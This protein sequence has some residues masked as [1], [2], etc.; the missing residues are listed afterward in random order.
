MAELEYAMERTVVIRAPRALVFRYF[1]DNQRWSAWWGAGSTIAAQ[2]GGK[3]YIRY[4]NGVEAS[5]EVVSVSEPASIRFTL[6]YASGKPMPPGGSMVTIELEEVAQGTRLHL[7]HEFSDSSARDQHVQGWRFQ[8]A[9]FSNVVTNELFADVADRVD[10]WFRAWR[11][12]DD[13]EREKL[14]AQ[15]ATPKI[16][17]QDRN[18]LVA[19]LSDLNAH[20]GAALRFMPGIV[21]ERKGNVRQ[22]QG[23]ALSDWTASGPGGAER[24]SGTS[25]FTFAP[26]GKIQSVAGVTNK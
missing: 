14:F 6:G 22:C 9:V 26:D 11:T 12:T 18:S 10:G 17:F 19:G 24:M 16:E 13:A 23:I 20:A 8:L 25:V 21:L 5:G 2:P 7:L 3:V 15:V 4:P 1:T